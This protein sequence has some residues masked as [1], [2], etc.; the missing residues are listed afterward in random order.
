MKSRKIHEINC[1]LCR[2]DILTVKTYDKELIPDLECYT[3]N[4][5]PEIQMPPQQQQLPDADP[6]I[7]MPVP[8]AALPHYVPEI[9][10]EGD[11]V[12]IN[13]V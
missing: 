13:F 4:A 8:A 2:A 5:Y 7:Q 9:F 10:D 11:N 3:N 6:E 1:S 12:V